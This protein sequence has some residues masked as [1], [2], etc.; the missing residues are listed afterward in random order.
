MTDT[1]ADTLRHPNADRSHASNVT[2]HRA[3]QSSTSATASAAAEFAR[4]FAPG[5]DMMTEQRHPTSSPAGE[6]PLSNLR[7]ML[8]GSAAPYAEELARVA[9]RREAL[10]WEYGVTD[11]EDPDMSSPYWDNCGKENDAHRARALQTPI[12]S[13]AD[14][15][16]GMQELH[17]LLGPECEGDDDSPHT[18]YRLDFL[19]RGRAL[20]EEVQRAAGAA[21]GKL[22]DGETE[23][24]LTEAGAFASPAPLGSDAKLLALWHSYVAARD[25]LNRHSGPDEADRLANACRSAEWAFLDAPAYSVSGITLKFRY[26]RDEWALDPGLRESQPDDILKALD[27]AAEAA[28]HLAAA[29]EPRGCSARDDF[30][31]LAAF[32]EWKVASPIAEH[33][34]KGTADDERERAWARVWRAVD[35]MKALPAR[36]PAGLAA[37]LRYLFASFGQG[38][39]DYDAIWNGTQPNEET[40]AD[41]NMGMLWC[42]IGEAERMTAPAQPVADTLNP[43]AEML[44]ALTLWI[45]ERRQLDELEGKH[46][47]PDYT[48]Y[49][50]L[51]AELL[52]TPARS[53]FGVAAKLAA[54]LDLGALNEDDPAGAER[55]AITQ[56][57]REAL[58]IA[59][60]VHRE[61]A[62]LL[63]DGVAIALGMPDTAALQRRDEF[64][65]L[66]RRLPTGQLKEFVGQM[67]EMVKPEP[68]A[69]A[70][71]VA[72][73]EA[74]APKPLCMPQAPTAHMV[75]AGAAAAGISREQAQ[76]IYAA[77]ADAY[78]QERAA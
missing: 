68:D 30:D 61:L 66:I 72:A 65:S 73:F 57:Q 59:D 26:L 58:T 2:A 56:A 16:A 38:P 62:D 21:L 76:A 63:A 1:H 39:E 10:A 55:E 49:N 42:T 47:S 8:L 9:A 67:R 50:R 6:S 78:R 75:E 60:P 51:S 34:P 11:G 71:T 54:A 28:E 25:R 17:Y 32:E 33:L 43:D 24:V 64:A 40:L 31:L 74:E 22:I 23:G 35:R 45:A 3:T 37:K 36:T 18:R 69:F 13:I 41:G 12:L 4:T 52:T 27:T 19:A 44:Q 48:E 46:E 29:A 14:V 70:D 20:L 15:C 7:R 53:F 77:M 5:A